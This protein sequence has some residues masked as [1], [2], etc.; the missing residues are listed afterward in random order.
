MHNEFL[1]PFVGLKIGKHLFDFEVG[2]SFF[3]SMEYSIIEQGNVK[4]TLELDKKETM[5]IALFHAEGTINTLCDR[6]NTPMD[7]EIDGGY[8]LIYK[9]GLEEEEDEML[10]VLHPDSY[11]VDITNP[12]YELITTQLP[13]RVL[14][15][16]GECD[17]EMWELIQQHIVNPEDDEDDFDD[18]D[19]D[20]EDEEWDFDEDETDSNDDDDEDWEDDD[21]D[22]KDKPIDPRWAILKNLN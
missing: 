14:H 4:V 1:I 3:E 7:L 16:E 15:D 8:K 6:C 11:Q 2:N 21:E 20:D 10:V 9:F 22:D 19:W 12:I 17:E 13:L 5:M 18:E